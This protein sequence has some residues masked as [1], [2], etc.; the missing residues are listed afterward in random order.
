MINIGSPP[1]AITSVGSAFPDASYTQAEVGALLGLDN[2]VA[3]RLLAAPHIRTRRLFL[4]PADPVT[5]RAPEES[6]AELHAKFRRGA[7]EIGGRAIANALKT[8]ALTPSD[9]GFLLCVTSTG[10]L[11]PGLSSLFSRE[12]G[13]RPDLVRADL[14]GMG[15][16]AGLNGLNPLAQWVRHHPEKVAVLVCCEIN[17]AMY[18]RDGTARTG[19]VNSLFGDGAA[20]AVITAESAGGPYV[21][22]FE[23][24]CLPD[25]WDAM[26]FDWDEN[27]GKWSFFLDRDIPYVIGS[28]LV[29]PVTR[30]LER[31]GL[32][33]ESISHW[34]LHTGGGAVID[35]ARQSLGLSEHDVRHTRSVL[36][37]FGNISSGSFLVSLERLLDEGSA[38]PGE[39]GVMITMGP[40]AQI[41][42]ALIEFGA[43]RK[44]SR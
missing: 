31:H 11:V 33:P 21:L 44:G 36:R 35:S 43:P 10:F 38:R 14:V 18:V 34:V 3:R 39:H 6:P 20:A 19:I 7:L 23:S 17:S 40:G 8:A 13:F 27:A 28:N 2:R 4:P 16:N 42:T 37:D 1:A 29:V 15:C 5:G 30:L 24:H 22:D 12:L 9:V 41:E 26:R 32:R 25:R